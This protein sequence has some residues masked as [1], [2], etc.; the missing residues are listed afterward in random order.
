MHEL[1]RCC[2]VF[3]V[4]SDVT[5]FI[6][7]DLCAFGYCAPSKN[8]SVSAHFMYDPSTCDVTLVDVKEQRHY[9]LIHQL[10]L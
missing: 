6:D 1:A 4:C 5:L 7:G 3:Y 10:Q 2:A 9:L 8:V